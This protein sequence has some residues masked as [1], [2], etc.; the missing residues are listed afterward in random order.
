[1]VSKAAASI[2]VLSVLLGGA[3]SSTGLCCWHPAEDQ[4]EPVSRVMPAVALDHAGMS[5]RE[6]ETTHPVLGDGCSTA[7]CRAEQ[8]AV[9]RNALAWEKSTQNESIVAQLAAEL[10]TRDQP[11]VAILSSMPPHPPP[12]TEVCSSI[13]RV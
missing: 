12:G 11:T 3:L 8:V 9:L 7:C 5:K 2:V 4:Y 10:L 13:L 1:M 6:V